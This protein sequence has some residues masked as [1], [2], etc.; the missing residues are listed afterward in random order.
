MAKALALLLDFCK[1]YDSVDR[2][3]LYDVLRWLGCPV[4]YVSALQALHD[5]TQVRFLANGYHSRWVKVTCGIRQGCPLAPLLFLF[6]LEALYRRID[7]DSRVQGILLK[8]EAGMVQLKIGGY[9]D[10][11][12]SYV[13]SEREVG[14]ILNITGEFALASGLRLNEGKL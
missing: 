8:S 4:E 6:V 9:A 2:A 10:D 5:G 14:F 7:A 1:A 11:S 12:A 3:F 13:R